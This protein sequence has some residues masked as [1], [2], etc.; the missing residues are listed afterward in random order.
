MGQKVAQIQA[1]LTRRCSA[2]GELQQHLLRAGWQ[3]GVAQWGVLGHGGGEWAAVAG[4]DRAN[5]NTNLMND[6]FIMEKSQ[7]PLPKPSSWEF[8]MT[9]KGSS[10][11]GGTRRL[12]SEVGDMRPDPAVRRRLHRLPPN[13]KGRHDHRRSSKVFVHMNDGGGLF[14]EDRGFLAEWSV[15]A[16][17]L[18]RKH[19]YRAGNGLVILPFES[20]WLTSSERE[21]EE[22]DGGGTLVSI[23]DPGPFQSSLP[24][25]ASEVV[26]TERETADPDSPMQ[27]EPRKELTVSNLPLL[28]AEVEALLDVLEE[29][30]AMQRRRRLD[31]LRSPYWFRRHWYVVA[32]SVPALGSFFLWM[33][34]QGRGKRLVRSFL[35]GVSSFLKERLRDPVISM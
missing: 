30:M 26:K 6:S 18:I 10:S 11:A 14:V 3:Q 1:V 34:R 7:H 12:S 13:K 19:L 35:H 9:A 17:A 28:A 20:N 21:H 32:T 27:E 25:W 4:F 24:A 8:S 29:I 5:N 2:I 22:E 15:E 23:P 16:M 33:A 31:H